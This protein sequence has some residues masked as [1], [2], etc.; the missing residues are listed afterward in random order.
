VFSSCFL[1]R[2]FSKRDFVLN[3]HGSIPVLVPAGFTKEE[4]KYDSAGNKEQ[5]YYY[6]N[7]AFFYIS[8]TGKRINPLQYIDEEMNIP[9]E[10]P[11]GGLIYKGVLPGSL[12]WR[13]IRIDSFRIGYRNVPRDWEIRFD[14]ASNYIS[15][16]PLKSFYNKVTF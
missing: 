4:I 8:T 5:V 16:Q 12:F 1:S 14:S 3:N 13:E 10:H 11:K 9:R 2:N 15:N 7:G 6:S